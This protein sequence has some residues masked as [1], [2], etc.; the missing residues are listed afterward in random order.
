MGSRHNPLP[1]KDLI[2]LMEAGLVKNNFKI[3]DLELGLTHDGNRIFGL[4]DVEAP[5]SEVMLKKHNS[6]YEVGFRGSYDQS[7]ASQAVFGRGCFICSNLIISGEEKISRKNTTNNEKD[8]PFQIDEILK[9]AYNKMFLEELRVELYK[10]IKLSDAQAHDIVS[11][12]LDLGRADVM[13]MEEIVHE[14]DG[15]PFK[16]WRP[17]VDH[18]TVKVRSSANGRHVNKKVE[19]PKIR[20][21]TEMAGANVV[22]PQM[23]GKVLGDWHNPRYKEFEGERN[24]WGLEQAFTQFTKEINLADQFK[25]TRNLV[26]LLDRVPFEGKNG[27]TNTFLELDKVMPKEEY[28]PE[29][30]HAV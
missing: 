2:D 22:S 3:N 10:S 30:A 14:V 28:V 12:S 27:M 7:L 24:V 15:K 13:D 18:K 17:V 21:A 26:W 1:H 9:K 25:R 4:F 20:R 23:L 8:M 16:V 5:S 19:E 29:E 11:V 6:N